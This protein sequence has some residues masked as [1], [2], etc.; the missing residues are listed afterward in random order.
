M[1]IEVDRAIWESLKTTRLPPRVQ[2]VTKQQETQRQVEVMEANHVVKPE[3]LAQRYSQ[4][5]LTPKPN[6]K[7]RFAIDYEPLN[8]ATVMAE[9]WPLPNIRDVLQRIGTKK[10][11]YY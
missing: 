9:S 10:E 8:R 6:G 4:V 3:P 2:T 5:M 7:W 1:E 11:M